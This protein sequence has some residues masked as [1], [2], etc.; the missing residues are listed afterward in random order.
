MVIFSKTPKTFERR[1]RMAGNTDF[2]R[3]GREL[4]KKLNE[5]DVK[6]ANELKLL[7]EEHRLCPR[8]ELYIRKNRGSWQYYEKLKGEERYIT[9]NHEKIARLMRK[10][11]IEYEIH[12]R[13]SFCRNVRMA[14]DRIGAELAMDAKRNYARTLGRIY[15]SGDFRAISLDKASEEWRR[16]QYISSTYMPEKKIYMT[17]SGIA[18]RSKSEKIIADRLFAFGVAFRYEAQMLI[19]GHLV[20]PDFTIRTEEG[21]IIIWEHMGLLDDA[22]YMQNAI[23]KLERYRIEGFKQHTNLICTDEDDIASPQ[24]IDGIIRKRLL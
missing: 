3:T 6:V 20:Y 4:L 8:G 2:Q 18:V 11:A 5:L 14:S 21:K 22:G 13:E 16:A 17:D 19:D 24:I 10:R 1:R 15:A 7:K 23:M 9:G 12:C